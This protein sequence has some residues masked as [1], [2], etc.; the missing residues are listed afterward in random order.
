MQLY[1]TGIN[2]SKTVL[3]KG[4]QKLYKEYVIE[5]KGERIVELL[6]DIENFVLQ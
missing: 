3:Y 5:V 1:V 6:G 4:G 2:G